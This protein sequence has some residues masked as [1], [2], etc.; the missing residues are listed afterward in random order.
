MK[1][2]IDDLRDP[3]DDDWIVVRSFQQAILYFNTFKC[4]Q[5]IS[6]D[7]DLGEGKN[8]YDVVK[9]L[10]DYDSK[11]SYIDTPLSINVHSAN[12]VGKTNIILYL[13]NYINV[14]YKGNITLIDPI[15]GN[16]MKGSYE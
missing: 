5:I 6:F 14:H 2:F 11:T 9:W 12:V 7:H 1:L 8:G 3:P 16:L 13:K 10:C 4:P 15:A